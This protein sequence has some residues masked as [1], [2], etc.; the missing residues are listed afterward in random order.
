MVHSEGLRTMR[1]L[2]YL[3]ET[4]TGGTVST[5]AS[6]RRRQG[7]GPDQVGERMASCQSAYTG[8]WTRE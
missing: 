6:W 7:K 8:G 2:L 3:E 4:Q 1:S 5:G